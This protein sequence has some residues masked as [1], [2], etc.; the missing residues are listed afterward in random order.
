MNRA[1]FA[2]LSPAAKLLVINQFGI[3]VGFY[4]LMPFLA[5]YMNDRLG[6]G[7]AV[8]GLVLGVR[9][10][11]QQGMFLLGGTAADRLG[12]RPMIIAGC[13]LRIVSFGLFAVFTSLP[14]LF[15]AA[16]LTGLAGALFN[17]AVRT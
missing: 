4:M 10:L 8:V 17:P 1:A 2:R 13:A 7:A 5:S 12:C 15:A 3:N 11:S 16:I 9:N 6:Y 14:G